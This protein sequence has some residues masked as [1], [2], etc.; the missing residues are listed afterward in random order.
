MNSDRID[1]G[2][3]KEVNPIQI[4]ELYQD[5]ESN[6]ALPNEYEKEPNMIHLDDSEDKTKRKS[7]NL[8]IEKIVRY[9]FDKDNV[10]SPLS[11]IQKL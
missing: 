10:N 3:V 1:E 6:L 7:S 4:K 8:D 11:K 2:S 5:S 9:S